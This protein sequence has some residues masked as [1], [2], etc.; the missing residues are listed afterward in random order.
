MVV[1]ELNW[2]AL[3]PFYSKDI[4]PWTEGPGRS[5]SLSCTGST[6]LVETLAEANTPS[7]Q[8]QEL[9]KTQ[10][11]HKTSSGNKLKKDKN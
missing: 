7:A 2:I 1:N 6:M 3:L 10:W 11:N 5:A 4:H 8:P 9:S